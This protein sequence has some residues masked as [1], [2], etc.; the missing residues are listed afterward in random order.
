MITG[1]SGLYCLSACAQEAAPSGER[2]ARRAKAKA[3]R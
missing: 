1:I 3:N 2:G